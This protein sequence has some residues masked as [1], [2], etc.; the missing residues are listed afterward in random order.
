MVI[1]IN[2]TL[3]DVIGLKEKIREK[4]ISAFSVSLLGFI[5]IFVFG[6]L[7]GGY[8]IQSTDVK[9]HALT[10]SA[11]ISGVF[12]DSANG[13]ISYFSSFLFDFLFFLVLVF[14]FGMTFLGVAAV[15]AAVFFKGAV[16][17]TALSALL[18]DNSASFFRSWMTYLPAA[19]LSMGVLLF[20]SSCAFAVSLKACRLLFLRE[21]ISISLKS[22]WFRFL[23]AL[24]M[25]LAAS[26]VHCILG[27]LAVILF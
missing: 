27:F 4:R 5:V 16:L 6:V 8:F 13:W 23:S 2:E 10:D 25:L 24:L 9:L 14:L 18:L 26:A 7:S 11:F 3:E 21:S 17:G 22:Y 20:F 19:A 1:S 12:A 15:P